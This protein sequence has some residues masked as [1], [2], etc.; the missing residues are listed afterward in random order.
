M[1]C[2]E[3][4]FKVTLPSFGRYSPLPS[5]YDKPDRHKVNRHLDMCVHCLA[6]P[7]G[8]D[9]QFGPYYWLA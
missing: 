1:R 4:T 5:Y 7:G 6:S 2:M 8:K 3:A 9:S